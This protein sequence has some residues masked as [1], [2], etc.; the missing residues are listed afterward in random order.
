MNKIKYILSS[1][2]IILIVMSCQ[3]PT[4]YDTTTWVTPI[5][6]IEASIRNIVFEEDGYI[7]EYSLSADSKVYVNLSADPQII[8]MDMDFSP[9]DEEIPSYNKAIL[10]KFSFF[11]DSIV[12]TENEKMLLNLENATTDITLERGVNPDYETTIFEGFEYPETEITFTRNKRSRTIS[13]EFYSEV[14][15]NCIR[16]EVYLKD[17]VIIDNNGQENTISVQAET[18]RH[19]QDT[20][21]VR[22][23]FLIKY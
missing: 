7:R 11:L 22:G 14:Y 23:N 1:I 13:A 20:I 4:D 12:L 8:W 19:L 17:S 9:D 18:S 10:K 3:S 21:F 2:V 6:K 16:K 5:G 15:E